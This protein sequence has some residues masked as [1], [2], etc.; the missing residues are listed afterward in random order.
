MFNYFISIAGFIVFFNLFILVVGALIIVVSQFAQR[1]TDQPKW[2]FSH[3]TRNEYLYA[4]TSTLI[5]HW[6]SYK[7]VFVAVAQLTEYSAAY[8]FNI[9]RISIIEMPLFLQILMISLFTDLQ[10]YLSHRF[11][12]HKFSFFWYSNGDHS[13]IK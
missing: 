3:I 7:T 1:C 12:T 2:S 11:V 13:L 5:F 4:I 10:T 6:I 8:G 9:P